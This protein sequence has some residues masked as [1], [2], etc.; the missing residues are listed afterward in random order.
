MQDFDFRDD[1]DTGLGI[2]A[3]DDADD[4]MLMIWRVVVWEKFLMIFF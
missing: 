1:I 4:T 2:G 3:S